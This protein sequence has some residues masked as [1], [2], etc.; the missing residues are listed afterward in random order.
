MFQDNIFQQILEA[1]KLRATEVEQTI[2][3]SL[4]IQQI[5]RNSKYSKLNSHIE[6]KKSQYLLLSMAKLQQLLFFCYFLVHE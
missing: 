2:I 1:Q 6:K 5:R 3:L 4:Q